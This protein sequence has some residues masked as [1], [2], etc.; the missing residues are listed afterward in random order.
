MAWV[1]MLQLN[2]LQQRPLAFGSRS[3]AS[4]TNRTFFRVNRAIAWHGRFLVI[5]FAAGIAR[6]PLNLVLLKCCCAIGV[7]TGG[8]LIKEPEASKRMMQEADCLLA[9]GKIHPGVSRQYP[10]EHIVEAPGDF[11]E[12]RVMGKVVINP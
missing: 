5:G 6:L 4:S 1:D 10:L 9:E 8:M 3:A 2:P 7:N 12:R 11:I